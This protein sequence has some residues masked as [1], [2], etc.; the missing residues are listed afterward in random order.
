AT[1]MPYDNDEQA[2]ELVRKGDGSLVTSVF[3]YNPEQARRLV[4]GVAPYNGRV[5]VSNRDSAKT[6]TGHGSPMPTTVHGGPGR[7]GGGEE[8][9]GIRSLLHYMQR[10]AVQGP[11]DVLTAVTGQW[12]DGSEATHDDRHPFRK[13]LAELRI[14]DQII[15]DKRTIT[16]EDIEHFAEFTGDNFYAQDRKSVV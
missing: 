12:Y 1:V 4:L 7:A 16:T 9:G 2:I 5:F 14:G 15:T 13:S 6:A 10:T 11:P 3:S 8:L